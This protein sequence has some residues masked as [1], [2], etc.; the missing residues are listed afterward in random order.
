MNN[1]FFLSLCLSGR[2]MIYYYLFFI[3]KRKETK[4]ELAD[5]GEM[6]VRSPDFLVVNDLERR[7]VPESAVGIERKGG[8]VLYAMMNWN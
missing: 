4:A 1:H 8:V 5:H 6:W 3:K 7:R 2:L